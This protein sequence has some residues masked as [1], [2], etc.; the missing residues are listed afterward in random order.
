MDCIPKIHIEPN[1]AINDIYNLL[2]NLITDTTIKPG[3]RLSENKLAQH[4]NVSRHPVRE[5]LSKLVSDGL[6]CVQPQRGCEVL[7]ISVSKL[8]QVLFV[9][10]AIECASI[11]NAQSLDEKSFN[12]IL[13]LIDKNIKEQEVIILNES[14]DIGTF[15]KLD[16]DFHRLICSFSDCPM[17]WDMIQS[18][19]GQLDRIRYLS[20][21]HESPMVS[22]ID[23]HKQIYFA[24]QNRDFD[25][26]LELM[27]K[28]LAL[29]KESHKLIKQ[30]FAQWFTTIEEE[31]IYN[32]DNTLLK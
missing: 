5:A 18:I 2:R 14:D 20:M 6:L 10:N 1:N 12:C 19:K 25:K 15:L 3:T 4:F 11:S 21:K 13:D 28:H 7:K 17:A 23:D 22:L 9:R 24:L 32:K 27:Q 26:S 29:I 16:D 8:S 31:A 30:K